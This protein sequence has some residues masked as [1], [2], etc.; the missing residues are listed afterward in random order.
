MAEWTTL[1]LLT[2]ERLVDVRDDSTS[3]NDSLYQGVQLLVSPE[4]KL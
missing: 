3:G 1:T 2:D 4:G